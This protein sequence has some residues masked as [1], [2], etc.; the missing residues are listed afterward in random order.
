MDTLTIAGADIVGGGKSV[1]YK[2]VCDQYATNKKVI[3]SLSG[4]TDCATLN[5]SGVLKAKAV[6]APK[7]VTVTATAAD[8][9][10]ATASMDVV[11]YPIVTKVNIFLGS[12][13]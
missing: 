10:G 12:E 7:Y 2:A 1:T 4:D 9:G 5:A 3:W 6:T 8:G 13:L 11:I